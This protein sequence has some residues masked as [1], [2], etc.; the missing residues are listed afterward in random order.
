[1][2]KIWEVYCSQSGFRYKKRFNC[3]HCVNNG[4][5]SGKNQFFCRIYN[6]E[7]NYGSEQ[8]NTE[9]GET[10]WIYLFSVKKAYR[11]NLISSS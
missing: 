10:P 6:R 4:K 8:L 11:T 1:M 7:I 2:Y 9:G 5:N 3:K